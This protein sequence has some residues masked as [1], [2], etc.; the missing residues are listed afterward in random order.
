[1]FESRDYPTYLLTDTPTL[2]RDGTF[3]ALDDPT[4]ITTETIKLLFS[5]SIGSMQVE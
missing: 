5:R 4:T 2:D 1:M 3:K